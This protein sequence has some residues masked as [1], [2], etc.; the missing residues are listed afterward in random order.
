MTATAGEP[1]P[2]GEVISVVGRLRAAGCVFAEEE[3]AALLRSTS[4][5]RRLEQMTQRREAGWPLEQVVGRVDFGGLQ[6]SVG[7]H[8]FVPRQRSL[9]L[10]RLATAIA[11]R[12]PAPVLLEVCAGAAPIASAVTRAVSGVEAHAGDIDVRALRHARRNLPVDAG[13]HRGHLL[14]AVPASLQARVTL[15]VAVPPYVPLAAAAQ[16]PR[17]AR[18]HEP[19]RALFGGRDGLDHVRALLDAARHRLAPDPRVLVELHTG[20]YD[21]AATHAERQGYRPR[22]HDGEDGQ[23]VVLD[24]AS[25]AGSAFQTLAG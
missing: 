20:Q 22:R 7:R 2:P 11:R 8:V 12:Q 5:P 9:L 18:E 19:A 17:E 15:L 4:D 6:L 10:A 23:T 24:L 13:V 3:A 14:D 21:A 16:L 1:D 25:R